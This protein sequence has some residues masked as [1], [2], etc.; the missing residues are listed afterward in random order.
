MLNGRSTRA[1]YAEQGFSLIEVT[2]AL[3]LFTVLAVIMG[4][5]YPKASLSGGLGR[6]FTYATR[7]A[8]AEVEEIRSSAFSYVTPANFSGSQAFTQWGITF[9]RTVTITPCG[10]VSTAPC[11]NN[12]NL[13]QVA[14]AV[15]WLEPSTTSTKTA[16]LTTLIHAFF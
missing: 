13:T 10:G 9:T 15:S 7:Q 6:N 16:T 4:A 5:Y 8:E 2:V 1:L 14:V 3:F 11:S 12:P